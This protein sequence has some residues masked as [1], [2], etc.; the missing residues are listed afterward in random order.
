MVNTSSRANLRANIRAVNYSGF[1]SNLLNKLLKNKLLKIL[2][3]RLRSINF[4]SFI[5][6]DSTLL[7]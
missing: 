3:A 6:I 1:S 4:A 5:L 2:H 7:D